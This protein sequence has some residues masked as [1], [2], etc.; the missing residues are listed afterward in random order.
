MPR[1]RKNLT[2]TLPATRVDRAMHR[3]LLTDARK[4]HVPLSQVLRSIIR[5]HYEREAAK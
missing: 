1:P 4:K 5:E 2:E 3:R